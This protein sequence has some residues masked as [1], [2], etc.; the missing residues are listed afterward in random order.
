MLSQRKIPVEDI[1][2]VMRGISQVAHYDGNDAGYR[3]ENLIRGIDYDELKTWPE[4]EEV[5]TEEVENLSILLYSHPRVKLCYAMLL[6]KLGQP[7]EAFKTYREIL[8]YSRTF[9]RAYFYSADLAIKQDNLDLAEEILL[10]MQQLPEKEYIPPSLLPDNKLLTN[11]ND[12]LSL[13]R[14][15]RLSCNN[16]F[17]D[18]DASISAPANYTG[19]NRRKKEVRR[20]AE[21]ANHENTEK[22]FYATLKKLGSAFF[23][24]AE[25]FTDD[26]HGFEA[27]DTKH[28]RGLKKGR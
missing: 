18:P 22:G 6:E 9:W 19:K 2:K 17:A 3:L 10:R 11:L 28:D 5:F 12:M 14:G 1:S 15:L 7:D 16:S 13:V 20:A 26:Y 24:A 4:Y 21:K 25:Q 27:V 8:L 23:V